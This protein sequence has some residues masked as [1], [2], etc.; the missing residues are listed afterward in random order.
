MDKAARI[1]AFVELERKNNA[2]KIIKCT[3][4]F[5]KLLN[6]VKIEYKKFHDERREKINNLEFTGKESKEELNGTGNYNS[7]E[8][9]E[10]FTKFKQVHELPFS[11]AQEIQCE[12]E[13]E[14]LRT[15]YFVSNAF[16]RET[17]HQI[18]R[19]HKIWWMKLGAS[20]GKYSISDQ[21]SESFYKFVTIKSNVETTPMNVERLSL[22]SLK[23]CI[24]DKEVLCSLMARVPNRKK[25]VVP[26]VIEAVVDLQ[27]ASL[28]L[29]LDAVHNSEYNTALHRRLAPYQLAIITEGS[30]EDLNVL[31]RFIELLV[32]ETEPRLEILRTDKDYETLDSIGVP[33]TII[34]DETALESGL[35]KLRSRNTTLS[36]TIH[37]NDVNNYLLKIFKAA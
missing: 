13:T 10:S 22:F 32:R 5:L 28:A 3:P 14:I 23:D 19:Q 11:I 18:Q 4:L 35:F 30:S 24:K 15:S 29:L 9:I 1:K 6:K 25:Q 26:D 21:R 36:E 20:P 31:A 16:S 34:L 7:G 2:M 8:F 27:V 17:F 12:N 37:L 33:Y